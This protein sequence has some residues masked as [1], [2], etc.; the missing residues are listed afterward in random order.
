VTEDSTGTGVAIDVSRTIDL[1][2]DGSVRVIS[3]P[4]HTVGHLSVLLHL[5]QGR[6]VLV[7]GDAAYTLRNIQEGILPMLTAD[8]ETSLRSLQEIKA[9]AQSEPKAIPVPSHDPC[10][11]HELRHVTASGERALEAPG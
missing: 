5:A 6:Q 3:T 9:F 11:W 10:A 7:I 2:G 1:L 8:D 4:G